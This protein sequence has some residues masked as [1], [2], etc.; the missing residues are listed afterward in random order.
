MQIKADLHERVASLSVR[1]PHACVSGWGFA[2]D[3]W[4][5]AET[6]H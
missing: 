4:K 3:Y 6:N 5:T 1:I 2:S